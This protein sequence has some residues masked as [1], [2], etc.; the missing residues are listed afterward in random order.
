MLEALAWLALALVAPSAALTLVNLVVYRA[1]PPADRRECGLSILIPARDEEN[2]IAVAVAAAVRAAEAPLEVLVLDDHSTDRTA[3]IVAE[4]AARDRRVR[5]LAASDLPAGWVGKQHACHVL[6]AHARHPL[7]LFHD[8]D[9]KLAPGAADRIASCLLNGPAA[10]ISGF[11]R[12]ETGTLGERLLVP[13]IHIVLLGYLPILLM[14][15]S[16]AIGLAAGC[17]QLIAV[18]RETYLACGGHRAIRTSLHDGLQLPR[19]FRR[20]GFATDLFDATDLARCRMYRSWRE[21][22]NGFLKNAH[23]GMATPVGLP[24]WTVLLGGGHV[25]PWAML[26]F[27]ASQPAPAS[28]LLPAASA[29]MIGI[30]IRVAIACRFRQSWI[31]VVVHPA[32]LCLLLAVQWTAL[33]RRLSGARLRWRDRDYGAKGV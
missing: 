25:M 24:I 14:R 5:L 7:L 17:G 22:W 19:A 4:I 20:A 15:R 12:Q 8:A 2:T 11:P 13:L 26:A 31:G 30:L 33:W 32:A 27:L 9:V 21:T 10:L 3:T 29:V 6:A 16:R 1:P 28:A 18:R 23:E